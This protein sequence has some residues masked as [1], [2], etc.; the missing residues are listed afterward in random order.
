MKNFYFNRLQKNKGKENN[1]SK[2]PL[3]Q[4]INNGI[5]LNTFNSVSKI[6][7]NR[8][9]NLN[10]FNNANNLIKSYNKSVIEV[11]KNENINKSK[12]NNHSLYDSNKRQII[13]IDNKNNYI[14]FESNNIEKE[15]ESKKI[16]LSKNNSI[17][18]SYNNNKTK[19]N[20]IKNNSYQKNYF[21]NN[22]TNINYNINIQNFTNNKTTSTNITTNK[23]NNTTI[24]NKPNKSNNITTTDNKNSKYIKH[25]KKNVINNRNDFHKFKNNYN[26]TEIN[27]S[28]T[29]TTFKEKRKEILKRNLTVNNYFKEKEKD[30]ALRS[31]SNNYIQINFTKKDKDKNN[32]IKT[33][34]NKANSQFSNI[35][36]LKNKLN[37]PIRLNIENV[38]KEKLSRLKRIIEQGSTNSNYYK[39]EISK[40]LLENSSKTPNK[41]DDKKEKENEKIKYIFKKKKINVIKKEETK[42]GDIK[43]QKKEKN[44]LFNSSIKKTKMNKKPNLVLSNKIQYTNYKQQSKINSHNLQMLKEKHESNKENKYQGIKYIEINNNINDDTITLSYSKEQNISFFSKKYNINDKS[45]VLPFSIEQFHIYYNKQNKNLILNDNNKKIKESNNESDDENFQLT[46]EI[47][48]LKRGLAKK[49]ELSNELRKKLKSLR[50]QRV[51]TLS[52]FGGNKIY[53]KKNSIYKITKI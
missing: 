26:F 47:I 25:L 22:I 4:Y 45:I 18:N 33:N 41:N 6:G 48:L 28:K 11:K 49:S 20:Y 12:F 40:H 32:N 19:N 8:S 23:N 14:R 46:K 44:V 9:E 30:N 43:V 15:K 17:Y 51:N 5:R 27:E 24:N 39:L 10:Y 21:N 53:K 38:N 50:M 42:E 29:S 31:S 2:F 52:L 34:K 7:V 36:E 35:K 3:K 16:R 37:L 13:N 1:N